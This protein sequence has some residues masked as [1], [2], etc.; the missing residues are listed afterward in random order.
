MGDIIRINKEKS[1]LSKKSDMSEVLEKNEMGKLL[2][3]TG[4]FYQRQGENC[5]TSDSLN[6]KFKRG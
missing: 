1:S 3:F 5:K 6:K 2:M 4:V